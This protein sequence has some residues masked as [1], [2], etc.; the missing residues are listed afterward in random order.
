M[1]VITVMLSDE[2]RD[3][4]IAAATNAREQAKACAE[5]LR[6]LP[7]LQAE[8]RG[9][10]AALGNAIAALDIN[11]QPGN[12]AAELRELQEQHAGLQRQLDDEKARAAALAAALRNALERLGPAASP[13]EFEAAR[14][15]VSHA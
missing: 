4:L 11:A 5:C 1:N 6:L 9:R 14:A 10:T 8:Y 3:T 15:L 2:Q 7:V 12:L 13:A